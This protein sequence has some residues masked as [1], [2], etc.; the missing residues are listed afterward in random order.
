MRARAA[1]AEGFIEHDGVRIHYEVFGTGETTILLMP[2]WTI[3]HKRFWKGQI[4]YLARHHRV[5][6]YD[7]PG[8]GRSDRP[9]DPRAYDQDAHTAYALKVLD[10]T[11]TGAAV[12]VGLSMAATWAI[13]LAAH[14]PARVGGVALIGPTAPV[15]PASIARAHTPPMDAEP[16]TMPSSRVPVLA[17]DPDEHWAKYN[18]AYWRQHYDDFLWFFLGQCFPEPHSTK[19][20]EDG[21]GWGRQTSAEVLV[22]ASHGTWP[23]TAAF[24]EW[25]RRVTCP[26]LLIHGDDDRVSPAGR[27]QTI[28]ELTGGRLVTLHGGGHIPL[29]RDPVQV[30]LLI[31]EFVQQLAPRTP[32]PRTWTRWNRRTKRVLYLS[33]PIGLGHARRDAAIAA[34]LRRLHPDVAIDWLAQHPVTRVLE[35][36]GEQ[37]HP[38]SRWLANE[39]AH[40]E[41]EAGEHDLHCFEAL[42]RMD[43]V[44]LANFMVFHDVVHDGAYDL[45][46][47]DEAWEVDHFLHENPELKRF[48]YAWLTDF[49]GYLPMPDAGPREALVAA[50]YN[51]E[52]IE[53]IARYPRIRDR[54]IFIGDPED[55]IE[56]TFGP[57]LPRIRDWTRQHYAFAGYAT[58]FDPA[59]VADRAALRAELGYRP[60]EQVCVVTVGGSGV[61]AALLHRVVDAYGA[62]ARRV[63]G[64]RMIVIT[65]PR[66]DPASIRP[67]PGLDIRPYV[68]DLHRH[69][70]ACDLAVVQGGLTTCM[71]LTATGR[72]FLYIPLQHHFEQNLHVP[73]RLDRYRAGRRLDYHDLT[74]EVLAEA[75]A[76]EIGRTTAY[77]PVATDGPQRAARLLAELL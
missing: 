64:L 29:A 10:A 32:A 25:C 56:G 77:R 46:V 48:A 13:D 52:M 43:E 21:V 65:G 18:R 58:G 24:T 45:V 68:P 11:G 38:A 5:V 36:A 14:H 60:D 41:G 66:I 61:G 40:I 2:T 23:A 30:N 19:Q 35:D 12:L 28:A 33:S 4:P 1:D 76:A 47:G 63:P 31:Q 54:A 42:R 57:G 8:N 70:A 50:D 17:P 49:V 9:L 3:I 53:H 44:L 71:E 73:H 59:A 22:A 67:A 51:A 62:A 72:P 16:P 37:V 39:S 75:I 15:P 34:E 7:G 26:V 69:L 6:A 27:S 55:V 20:I 74:P